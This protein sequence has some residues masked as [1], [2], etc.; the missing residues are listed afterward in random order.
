MKSGQ[1]RNTTPARARPALPC[2]NPF[3]IRAGQKQCHMVN[4]DGAEGLNPFE[5]RAGQKRQWE[6]VFTGPKS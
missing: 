2:L 3:E 5:I 1:A 4:P 6:E